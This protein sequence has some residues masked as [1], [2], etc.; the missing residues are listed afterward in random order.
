MIFIC[1]IIEIVPI[2]F[3]FPPRGIANLNFFGNPFTNGNTPRMSIIFQSILQ[4]ITATIPVI[5]TDCRD[6]IPL[7]Y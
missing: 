5:E 7:G 1:I 3:V 6:S 4:Q 2:I